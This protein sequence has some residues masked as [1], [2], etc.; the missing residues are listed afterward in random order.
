MTRPSAPDP[1]V[2]AGIE[3]A[4]RTL[5]YAE[6]DLGERRS[7]L[8]GPAP[9]PRLLR[10][11]AC[12]FGFDAA[13]AVLDLA[14]PPHL[15]TVATALREIFEGSRARRLCVA[16]H[17][18]HATSFFAPL[19]EGMTAAERFE[20]LRQE[21]AMLADARVARPVRVHATPV[22]LEVLPDGRRFHW[23]HVLRLSESVHA[24][25]GHLASQFG[26]GVGHT[27]VDAIGAAATVSAWLTS[28]EERNAEA[29][30]GDTVPFALALGTYGER[31]EVGV[32]RGRTWHFAHW[33]EAAHRDDGAYF[34]AALLDRLAI[35]PERVRR[36][37]VYGDGG[38]SEV[39]AG[40]EGFLGLE[41]QPLDPLRL[42]RM[43]RSQE[44]PAAL[45]AF[46]PAVGAALAG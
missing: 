11:C 43:A 20:Q 24:R 22:R 30:D 45:A 38:R 2:R 4:G 28:P 1:R 23:H 21:A 18:W 13:E 40:I 25:V 32:C 8:H 10:L 16:V 17:P 26:E 27:F 15:E 9:G 36:L 5:R 29:L 31:L 35:P 39:V 6:V 19:P 3:L 46:T 37:Y 14:G 12:D 44:D 34:G 33:S 41:A 7:A 42:F